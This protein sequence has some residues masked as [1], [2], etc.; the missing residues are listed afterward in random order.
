M[1]CS[2]R[3]LLG[4]EPCRSLRV[5]DLKV[6]PSPALRFSFGGCLHL[7]IGLYVASALNSTNRSLASTILSSR[8]IQICFRSGLKAPSLIRLGFNTVVPT[9]HFLGVLGSISHERHTLLLQRLSTF[10]AAGHQA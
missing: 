2:S 4:Q 1:C 5:A 8:L 6:G 7:E 9:D 10:L 3:L